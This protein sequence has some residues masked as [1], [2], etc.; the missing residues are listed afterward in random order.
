MKV[1]IPMAGKSKRFFDEGYKMPK[2]F[3]KIGN[4]FVIENV[5]NMFNDDDE[6]YLIFSLSQKKK[7]S[8]KINQIKNLKKKLFITY[9]KDH[10]KGPVNSI[11]LANFN[12]KNSKVIISYNDFF[13]NWDY[14]KFLRIAEG[15]DGSIVSFKGFH[16]S[17][18]SGT[19]YCY[20][21]SKNNLITHLREKKSFTKKPYNEPAS[22]GIYYFDKYELFLKSAENLKLKKN[23]NINNELY[24]SQT[25]LN[26]FKSQKNILDY[27]VENF[28]SLG[29]PK[30]YE[31][32]I[33]WKNY[34]EIN[35]KN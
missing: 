32:F 4:K 6:F 8:K 31:I 3:L 34:F 5:L 26:L 33:Y 20:L 2:F 13:I 16:P 10:N 28:I 14:N 19:L 7:Y 29:T 35:E 15:Y 22:V 1:I 21:R 24:V 27:R 9:I 30:D 25:Y 11:L 17:S 18:F 23:L 12:F